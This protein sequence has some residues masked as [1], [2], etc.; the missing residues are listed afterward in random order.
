MHVHPGKTIVFKQIKLTEWVAAK[1]YQVNHPSILVHLLSAERCNQE[2]E[3]S[4]W[5]DYA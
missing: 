3:T 1:R 2:K 5:S 4:V